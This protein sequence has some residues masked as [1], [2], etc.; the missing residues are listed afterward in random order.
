MCGGDGR[1]VCGDVGG[2]V[3]EADED[4]EDC[5]GVANTLMWLLPLW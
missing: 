5:G 2:V 3:G 1:C 4:G